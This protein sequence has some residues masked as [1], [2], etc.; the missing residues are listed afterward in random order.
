MT[1]DFRNQMFHL[2]RR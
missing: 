2:T 1:L